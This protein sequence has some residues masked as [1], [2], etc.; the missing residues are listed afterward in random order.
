MSLVAVG[1]NGGIA[2]ITLNR[3][4]KR[5]A[6]SPELIEDLHEKISE[7][8]FDPKVRVILLRGEG[9]DFCA[10]MDLNSMASGSEGEVMDHLG[11]AQV[12]S[13]LYLTMRKHPR[14][15]VAAV[16]GRAIGGGC[17]LA[18]A[19]DLILATDSA[20]FR[21]P[22]VNLGFVAGIV[23]SQLR[24][25]VGEKRA[26]EIIALG[27]AIP[28]RQAL[29]FGMVNQVWPES[30]F[31]QKVEGYIEALAG[32][33]QSALTLTKDLMYHIDGMGF[34]AAMHAGLYSNALARMTPDAKAGF[35]KFVRKK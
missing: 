29:E 16:Q 22:E 1:V 23:T 13:D 24:R 30:A 4:E 6:L 15:I 18:A 34:E 7:A 27:E 21:Y 31:D 9:K 12:L 25:V 33:S 19:S 10:G 14:P 32:K 17:G 3:P 35:E 20:E 8:G 26:F 11:T 28:A 2:R 5:N